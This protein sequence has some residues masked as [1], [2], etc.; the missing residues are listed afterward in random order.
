MTPGLRDRTQQPALVDAGR[1]YPGIDS[2]LDPDGDGDGADTATFALEVGQHPASFPLLDGLDVELGQ[3]V[4][5][6]GAADQKR[7]D[8][9]V[10][11]ALEGRAVGDGQQLFGLLA[12]QQFPSRVPFWLM[13]GMSVRLAASSDPIRLFRLASPTSFRTA[14]S[15]TFIVEG[16]N[17]SMPARHSINKDRERGRLAQNWNRSSRAFP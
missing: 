12:G 8:H 11:L 16:D 1:S 13:L 7:Q 6:E 3:L 9:I 5:P 2:L 15:R 17:D 14:D 4:P 10:A